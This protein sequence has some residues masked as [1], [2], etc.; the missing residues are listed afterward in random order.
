MAKLTVGITAGI[1]V[2][3]FGINPTFQ[4]H[5]GSLPID[6]R[7]ARHVQLATLHNVGNAL[8]LVKPLLNLVQNLLGRATLHRKLALALLQEVRAKLLRNRRLAFRKGNLLLRSWALQH[9]GA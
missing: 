1:G 3:N 4:H 9:L 6:L 2:T 8:L 7:D 5:V